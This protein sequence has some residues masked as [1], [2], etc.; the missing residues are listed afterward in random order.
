MSI[1]DKLRELILSRYRSMTEFSEHCGIK[2]QTIMSILTRGVRNASVT[3]IIKICQTLGI[4]TDELAEGRIT[5]TST[6]NSNGYTSLEEIVAYCYLGMEDG[7]ITFEG[8]PLTESE[9]RYMHDAI[10]TNME[11]LKKKRARQS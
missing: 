11:I 2:Y 3:N 6:A 7:T 9:A 5:Y 8:I 1:E 10:A 4:S